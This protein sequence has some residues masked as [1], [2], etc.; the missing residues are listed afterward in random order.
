MLPEPV[1]RCCLLWALLV[2][3]I[4]PNSRPLEGEL[5]SFLDAQK[6]RS[7]IDRS[8]SVMECLWSEQGL[9]RGEV[10]LCSGLVDNGHA[11]RLIAGDTWNLVLLLTWYPTSWAYSRNIHSH[12]HNHTTEFVGSTKKPTRGLSNTSPEKQAS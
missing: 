7:F 11:H 12:Q 10:V 6:H 3:I 1:V 9:L 5:F 4:S 8:T 2:G